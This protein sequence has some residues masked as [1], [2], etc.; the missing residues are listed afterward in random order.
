VPIVHAIILGITQGLS[1]F[2][3]ISSSGHLILVPWLFG[4]NDFGGNDALEKSFDVALHLGTLVGAF[5][6]FRADL[7]RLARAALSRRTVAVGAVAGSSPSASSTDERRLA[8]LLVLASVPAALTGAALQSTIE[9]KL[10]EIWLIAVMLIVFGL[11]LLW[12]DR[13]RGTRTVDRFQARDAVAMGVGQ[14]AA[15]VPGVSRSGITITVARKAGFNRDAAARLSFLM[16]LPIIAG[17]VAYKGLDMMSNGGIPD[18]MAPAFAWGIVTSGITGYIAVWGT[19]RLV[20]SH[21]FTPFVVYRV[22]LGLG[23]L[24][25]LATPYR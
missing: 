24:A 2:L 23:V 1:E 5:A 10:G 3:P 8:W 9:E 21:S 4:W 16:S 6:F 12:A 22:V 15:L 7:M 13:M 11:V 14:A 19:L 25:L 17:A 18:G 20:T